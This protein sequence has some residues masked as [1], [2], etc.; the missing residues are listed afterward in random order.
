VGSLGRR[1]TTCTALLAALIV[2]GCQPPAGPPPIGEVLLVVDTD[3]AVPKLVGRL[4]VDLFTT[5]GTWYATRDL[6]L[7]RASPQSGAPSD[8]PVSFAI[9]L[10]AQDPA[11]DVVARLRAYGEGRVRDYLGER[12]QS[13]PAVCDSIRCVPSLQPGVGRPPAP[14]ACCPLVMPPVPPPAVGPR[15]IDSNGN[16]VTPPSEPQPLLAIDRLVIVHIEPGVVGKALV[17]LRAACFGTMADIGD[18]GALSTCVDAENVRVAVTPAAL[19]ADLAAPATLAGSSEQ[20]Y[21]TDCA[22]PP[23]PG[24]TANGVPLHDDEVCVRGGGF[25]FGGRDSSSGDPSMDPLPERVAFMSSF[26]I[27]RYEVTVGRYRQAL[28]KGFSTPFTGTIGSYC[29]WTPQP[30]SNEE[31]PLNCITTEGARAFCEFAGGRLPTEAQWEYVASE[32]GREFKSHYPWGDIDPACTDVDYG[33]TSFSTCPKLTSGPATV[34]KYE[35]DG[36]DVTPG[37]GPAIVDLGGNVSEFVGDTFAPFSSNCW[38]AAP[39]ADPACRALGNRGALRGGNYSQ[40]LL[41]LRSTQRQLYPAETYSD[42]V[43]FRCVRSV[44]PP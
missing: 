1:S 36:G 12:F 37:P 16:D 18:F 24:G 44:G 4:R 3:A 30:G 14:R 39:L 7:P 9:A 40:G 38:L 8:W 19:D 2:L 33:R 26:L 28:S 21:A 23:R 43:G 17:V 29:K 34:T 27:D 42:E 32:A 15:M 25:V 6:A 22:T 11:K 20:A 31:F 35:R 10:G 5:D 41:Q 13:R